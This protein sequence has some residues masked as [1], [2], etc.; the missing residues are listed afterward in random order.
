MPTPP[1]SP[2]LWTNCKEAF[3]VISVALSTTT[4]L[5]ASVDDLVDALKSQTGIIKATSANDAD[6]KLLDLNARIKAHQ[7]R[8]AETPEPTEAKS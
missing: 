5:V 2:S 6:I 4:K 3:G 8:I 1:V 7:L